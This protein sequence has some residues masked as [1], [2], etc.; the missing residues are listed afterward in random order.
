MQ[1]S[2]RM[3]LPEK[4]KK[5]SLGERIKDTFRKILRIENTKPTYEEYS[6]Y[7]GRIYNTSTELIDSRDAKLIEAYQKASKSTTP[8][9]T[10]RKLGFGDK[11]YVNDY[12][13]WLEEK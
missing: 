1:E 5:K 11:Y 7:V 8:E 13:A 9:A 3:F 2:G 6:K 12:Y 10:L 4:P